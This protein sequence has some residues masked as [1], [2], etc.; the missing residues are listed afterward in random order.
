MCGLGLDV[1]PLTLLNCYS[2]KTQFGLP[3][4]Q[5]SSAQLKSVTQYSQS[6]WGVLLGRGLLCPQLLSERMRCKLSVTVTQ[7]LMTRRE[8]L[9]QGWNN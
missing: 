9:D 5:A 7:M 6:N 4:G 8:L 3:P 2:Q 1:F